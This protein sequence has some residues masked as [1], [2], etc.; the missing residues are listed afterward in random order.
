[1][2]AVFTT[3]VTAK[4]R[5]DFWKSFSRLRFDGQRWNRTRVWRVYLCSAA[6]SLPPD[7]ET[8][9][10]FTMPVTRGHSAPEHDVGRGFHERYPL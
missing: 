4:N 6:K 3:L 7:E 2:I 8:A 10:G 9:P 1:M 5:W